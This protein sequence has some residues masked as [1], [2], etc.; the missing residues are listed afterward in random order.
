MAEVKLTEDAREDLRD[1]DAKR[2][3]ATT[4]TPRS[5]ELQPP[6]GH[7]STV[8]VAHPRVDHRLSDDPVI[9]G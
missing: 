6:P 2:G 3:A 4:R 9:M 1:M 5:R 8:T 7:R